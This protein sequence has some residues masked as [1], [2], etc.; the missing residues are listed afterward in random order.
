VF[1]YLFWGSRRKYGLEWY[2]VWFRKT[3]EIPPEASGKARK[4]KTAGLLVFILGVAFGIVIQIA[5]VA[6]LFAL[7]GYSIVFLGAREEAKHLPLEAKK[8][9]EKVYE[10]KLRKMW[11]IH[12]LAR[13]IVVII[14]AIITLLILWQIQNFMK[15][16][17]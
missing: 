11:I 9:F 10:N 16:Y 7:I 3:V 15:T 6:T 5:E 8:E 17:F 13:A 14:G 2:K 12:I 4:I 1:I